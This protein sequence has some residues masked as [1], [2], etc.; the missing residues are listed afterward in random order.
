MADQNVNASDQQPQP[1]DPEPVPVDL[2][3]ADVEPILL[4]NEP[5]PIPI[6]AEPEEQEEEE[7]I[8]LVEP[9]ES[10][11]ESKVKAIGA[12]LQAEQ[13]KYERALNLTG[14]GATRCRIFHSRVAEAPLEHMERSINEWLDKEEIEIKHVNQVIG[15]MEGKTPRPN[16]VVT[17]WY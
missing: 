7:A 15:I 6:P 9:S 8:S 1:I 3:A 11:G 16:V 17:V 10:D 4:E 13:R 5:E 14:Q 12:A 2:E